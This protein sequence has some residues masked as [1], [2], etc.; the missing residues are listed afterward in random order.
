[1]SAL[2]IVVAGMV[3]TLLLWTVA[4]LWTDLHTCTVAGCQ[5]W[6]PESGPDRL[7]P[8]H[9]DRALRATARRT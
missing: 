3:V 2:G 6:T 9:R 8:G 1:M 4:T 7:C 5:E